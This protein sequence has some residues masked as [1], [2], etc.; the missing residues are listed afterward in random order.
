MDGPA[1]RLAVSP[2][3]Q[4]LAAG[5]LTGR[6]VVR[7]TRSWKPIY[8]N[9][10]GPGQVT[11]LKFYPDCRALLAAIKISEGTNRLVRV[12]LTGRAGRSSPEHHK[13]MVTAL[14]F[15]PDGAWVAGSS[16]D[17]IVRLWGSQ[18]LVRVG[19][20]R[21]H[22]GYVTSAAFSPDGH[23]LAMASNDDTVKLW[24]VE[25]RQELF[26]MPGHIAPWTQLAFSPDGT[27]L[28]GCGEAG[29]VRVWR[30]APTP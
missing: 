3:A 5:T 8:T 9:S 12:E 30:A 10:C 14:A 23:T 26:T 6:I 2:N 4:W 11:A 18:S 15:S 24:S 16:R 20:F 27:E 7:D 22:S 25:N 19:T 29:L 1:A 28:V 13:G 17:G 21:G